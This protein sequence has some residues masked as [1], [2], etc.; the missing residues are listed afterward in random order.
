MKRSNPII[1]YKDANN[2]LYCRIGIA[3][4]ND[5][6]SNICDILIRKYSHICCVF[7]G[8]E[9]IWTQNFHFDNSKH[10]IMLSTNKCILCDDCVDGISR[11]R[12]NIKIYIDVFVDKIGQSPTPKGVGMFREG[13]GQLID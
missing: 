1:V 10:I 5:T 7:G 11:C 6:C 3:G 4:T 8:A 2:C 12:H 9:D 13:Y